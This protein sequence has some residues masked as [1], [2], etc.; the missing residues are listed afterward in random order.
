M[1][2][3][4]YKHNMATSFYLENP[5][6]SFESLLLMTVNSVNVPIIKCFL[7]LEFVIIEF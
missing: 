2:Y 1:H 3:L 4:F 7:S 6:I 5:I